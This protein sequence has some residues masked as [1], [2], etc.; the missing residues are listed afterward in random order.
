MDLAFDLCYRVKTL[1][2]LSNFSSIGSTNEKNTKT[3][4]QNLEQ[5]GFRTWFGWLE[6]MQKCFEQVVLGLSETN[7]LSQHRVTSV[8]CLKTYMQ[9]LKYNKL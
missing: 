3:S 9:F 1:L 2:V 8:F 7:A 4:L 5:L 6:N